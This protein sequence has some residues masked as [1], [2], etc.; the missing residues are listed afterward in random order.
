MK[1]RLNPESHV[2]VHLDELEKH[3]QKSNAY[4]ETAGEYDLI[5]DPGNKDEPHAHSTSDLRTSEGVQLQQY[6]ELNLAFKETRKCF[7]LGSTKE[8]NGNHFEL[9]DCQHDDKSN[10]LPRFTTTLYPT[11]TYANICKSG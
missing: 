5:K 3:E 9:Y 8:V 11:K 6:S 4:E 10:T 1:E 2:Y 7:T